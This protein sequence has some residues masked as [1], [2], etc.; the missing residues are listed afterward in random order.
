[1]PVQERRSAL[2]E[3]DFGTRKCPRYAKEWRELS[4]AE[5]KKRKEFSTSNDENGVGAG[6]MGAEMEGLEAGEG[7]GVDLP[8]AE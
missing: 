3:W 1:M 6:V 2:K 5:K 8:E 7:V 4:A